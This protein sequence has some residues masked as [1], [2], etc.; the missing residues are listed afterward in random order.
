MYLH[1]VYPLSMQFLHAY[2]SFNAVVYVSMYQATVLHHLL[3]HSLM[4]YIPF[5]NFIHALLAG[6]GW[7]VQHY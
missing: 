5:Q 4:G 3:C 6:L 2:S 1:F 7:V